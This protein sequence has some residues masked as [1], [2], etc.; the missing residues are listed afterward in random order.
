MR[1]F[2]FLIQFGALELQFNLYTPLFNN[3]LY[4]LLKTFLVQHEGLCSTNVYPP[5]N[6]ASTAA[7]RPR[8]TYH[9]PFADLNV[10][11]TDRSPSDLSILIRP[12]HISNYAEI[13][14]RPTTVFENLTEEFTSKR[15]KVQ[16]NFNM[17]QLSDR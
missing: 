3:L 7:T 10:R 9:R 1:T 6:T 13:K 5:G 16:F 11:T 14:Y 8:R 17:P 4:Q 15:N 2:P 12:R